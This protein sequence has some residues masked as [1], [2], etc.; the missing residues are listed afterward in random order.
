MFRHAGCT[1]VEIADDSLGV[2]ERDHLGMGM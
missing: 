2:G 1:Q